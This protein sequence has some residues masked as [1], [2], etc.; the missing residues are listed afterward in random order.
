MNEDDDKPGSPEELAAAEQL[1]RA[2][3]GEGPLPD[4]VNLI[5][6]ATGRAPP[7]GELRA[8]GLARAALDESLKRRARPARWPKWL[9]AVAALLVLVVA[10]ASWLIGD[11]GELPD[12]LRAH[13]AGLLVPGPFP[14]SQ[15]AAERLDVVT[16]DRLMA[17]RE[18]RYRAAR[19]ER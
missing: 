5:A 17:F 1:A 12:R 16:T 9:G 7:L 11:R 3:D 19:G 6:A 13:S 10:L 15:T 4:E 14:L 18:V 2:L 8:R